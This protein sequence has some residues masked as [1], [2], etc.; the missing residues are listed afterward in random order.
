MPPRP[1]KTATGSANILMLIIVRSMKPLISWLW[2]TN[3]IHFNEDSSKI[4]M[5]YIFFGTPK[6]LKQ[7]KIQIVKNTTFCTILLYL[8]STRKPHKRQNW[9]QSHCMIFWPFKQIQM[10]KTLR[11]TIPFF[12]FYFE[13]IFKN[14][15]DPEKET[16]WFFF[17]SLF[18]T[19]PLNK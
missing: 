17:P 6:L 13:C 19:F 11:R 12:L 15:I 9:L 7:R 14:F 1:F 4:V 2:K 16:F 10:V 5:H 8:F 3:L 18:F